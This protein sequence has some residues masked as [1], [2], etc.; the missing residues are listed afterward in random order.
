M[1]INISKSDIYWGYAALLFNFGVGLLTLPII[2]N[3]LSAEEVGMN[4]LMLSIGQMVA[5]FDCGFSGILGR[6]LTYILSGAQSITK[7]GINKDVDSANIN[8]HLLKVVIETAKYIYKR[9]SIVVLIIMLT[10]G[11]MYMYHVT[12]SFTNINNSFWIWLL[13]SISTYFNMYFLYYNSL[14]SGAG[15]VKEERQA[16][17]YSKIVYLLIC[18]VLLLTGTGLMSIAIAYFISPFIQRWYSHIKFYDKEMKMALSP[19]TVS[20]DDIKDSF[21]KMW[22]LA[23]RLAINAFGTYAC[24]QSGMFICGIFLSLNDAASYGLML[25]LF[26]VLTAVSSNLFSTY[27]VLF[28]KLRV[29]GLVEELRKKLT[30]SMILLIMFYIV[31]SLVIVFIGPYAL[32]LLKSDSKLPSLFVMGLF[33]F[34]TLLS[35]LHAQS[36]VFISTGNQVPF[37]EASIYSGIAIVIL[38]TLFLFLHM[39]M[40][41]MVL[42]PLIVHSTYNHWYW[43]RWVLREIK[44]GPIE[45]VRLGFNNLFN[46]LHSFGK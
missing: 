28:C 34:E 7:Q 19:Y 14:L 33:A 31:G 23:K 4:Y 30:S 26:S 1:E 18:Y 21:A 35:N 46:I 39:G 13:F 8:Y 32:D 12:N 36:A 22:Y 44:V 3:K 41:S 37:V 25:Q 42:S 16:S 45:F 10:F 27:N 6:N 17:V 20:I 9:I 2:L 43:P 5:L 15:L 38:T 29:Q 11:T 24:A 40:I